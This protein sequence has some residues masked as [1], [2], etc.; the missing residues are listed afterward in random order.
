MQQTELFQES[1][2]IKIGPSEMPDCDLV[3][4]RNFFDLS[5]ND[6]YFQTLLAKVQ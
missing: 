1:R 2:T 4:I 5:Q 6:N 3:W